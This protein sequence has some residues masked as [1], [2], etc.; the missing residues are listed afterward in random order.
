MFKASL[1]T[2]HFSFEAYSTT[3]SGAQAALRAGLIA[4]ARQYTLFPGQ[5]I[6]DLWQDVDI[7]RLETGC[8]YRDK[9]KI[10][11]L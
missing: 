1:E 5:L 8:C 7:R 4:H 10:T 9:H 6:R 2:R 11:N 3:K